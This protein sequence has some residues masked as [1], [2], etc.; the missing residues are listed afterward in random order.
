ANARVR[1]GIG[2]PM[3]ATLGVAE[4]TRTGGVFVVPVAAKPAQPYSLQP[5]SNATGD[6]TVAVAAA[7]PDA[8]TFVD[9]GALVLASQPP[10][11]TSVTPDGTVE[12]DAGAPFAPQAVFNVAIDP[13]S[14][15]NGIVIRDLTASKNLAG[16]VSASGNIVRFTSSEA[17]QAGTQYSITVAPTIRSTS[18][19]PFNR[20][21][22]RQFR[23]RALPAN[24]AAIRPELISITIPDANGKSTIRGRVGALPGG[25]QVVAVRRGRFFIVTYDATVSTDGSFAFDAG[26][27]DPKDRITIDDDIDLQVLDKVSKSII[28]VIPLNFASEDGR[29]IIAVPSKTVTVTSAD[30]ISITIEEGT[31]DVRTPVTILKSDKGALARVPSFDAEL[32]FSGGVEVKFDGIAKKRMQL[33][34]PAPAGA[35]AAKSYFLGYLGESI[36]GPRVELNDS[37]RLV[38]GKFTTT[39]GEGSQSL[40]ITTTA[41]GNLRQTPTETISNPRDVKRYLIGVVRSGIYCV[42]DFTSAVGWGLING[43][44]SG[45]DMFFDSYASLF[46]SQYTFAETRGRALIPVVP[47]KPFQVVGVDASTG[48]ERFRK[49]YDGVPAGDPLTA[50]TVPAPIDAD[51]GPYPVFASPG[52]FEVVDTAPLGVELTSVRGLK[53]K[54]VGDDAHVTRTDEAGMVELTNVNN[55]IVQ[56]ATVAQNGEITIPANATDRVLISLYTTNVDP[57]APVS[58]T[59]NKPLYV[60][61]S[62]APNDVDAYFKSNNLIAVEAGTSLST[63][64]PVTSQMKFSVD[65]QARRVLIDVNGALQMGKTYRIT[66]SRNIQGVDASANP[67]LRLAQKTNGTT[68][69]PSLPDDVHLF[70]VTRNPGGQVAEMNLTSGTV[71]DLALN[72]NVALVSSLDGG[73]QAFDISDPAALSGTPSPIGRTKTDPSPLVTTETGVADW[74]G[75]A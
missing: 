48:L 46:A 4:L 32:N 13:T 31:F 71:R 54:V 72:G 15:A 52:R 70:F 66:L 8:D 37:L 21:V 28:A 45:V 56:S 43:V 7:S 49:V 47:N 16:T 17:L 62:T 24:N 42:I 40:R 51:T 2:S 53:I 14:V 64:S 33:E 59:F 6:G 1:S 10:Q 68:A 23:T 11:L 61:P 9:F 29:T 55:T 75:I 18:G 41:S 34:L 50:V 5:R 3:T 30:G 35:S 57:F 27:D 69:G 74:W 20:T 58:I 67:G 39:L 12:I 73:I 63:L 44:T 25:S 26:D 38:D 36:R 22:T 65:S 60:G 19:T